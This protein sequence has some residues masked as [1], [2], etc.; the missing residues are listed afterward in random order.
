MKNSRFI[1]GDF[2]IERPVLGAVGEGR[3]DDT[4]EL[5]GCE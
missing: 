4:G 1:E 2:K 3:A 5:V